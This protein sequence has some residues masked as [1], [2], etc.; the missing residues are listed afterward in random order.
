MA[1]KVTKASAGVAPE[2]NSIIQ[3]YRVHGVQYT[4][5]DRATDGGLILSLHTV[6]LLVQ[7]DDIRRMLVAGGVAP[8]RAD[9]YVQR[10]ARIIECGE[11]AH[12]LADRMERL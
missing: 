9:A 6:P 11:M 10:M 3:N 7:W 12:S 2:N 5:A 8:E 1:E 4:D